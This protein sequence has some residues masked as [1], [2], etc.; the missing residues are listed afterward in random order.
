MRSISTLYLDID[1]VILGKNDPDSMQVVLARHAIEFLDICV[2][3]YTCHWLTTHCANGDIER[4]L[5][6]LKRYADDTLLTLARRVKPARWGTLKTEAIDFTQKFLWF[7]DDPLEAEIEILKQ[8]NSLHRLININTMKN[9]DD[10][11]KAISI[12]SI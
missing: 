11:L 6:W 4:P 12:V 8:N 1:G 5:N 7:D 2:N 3:N 9:P 10:L